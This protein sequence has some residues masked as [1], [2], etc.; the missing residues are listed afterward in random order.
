MIYSYGVPEGSRDVYVYRITRATVDGTE[1]E[2]P[3]FQVVQ[4]CRELGLKTVPPLHQ[5]IAQ[6]E[7]EV[8]NIVDGYMDNRSSTL[9]DRHLME[10]IVVR[11]ENSEGT[12]FLKSKNDLFG[13]LE[14][15]LKEDENY[16]DVE[17]TN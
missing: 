11:I 10:G 17:E 8:M 6:G 4:R 7:D 9:D 1:T 15:Y 16:V 2:L 12:Q 13:I 3:W 14:G 5:F